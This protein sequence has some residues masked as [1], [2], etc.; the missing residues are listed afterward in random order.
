M[1]K[2]NTVNM[3]RV[4]VEDCIEV[5]PNRFELV[6]LAAERAKSI[7]SGAPLTIDR[8]NDKNPVIALREIA[9][10]TIDPDVLRETQIASLQ[11]HNKVDEVLEENLYAEVQESTSEEGDYS[12]A[13]YADEDIFSQ[14]TEVSTEEK[15]EFS[16]SYSKE[17]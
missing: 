9:T 15:T 5:V 14:E 13:S 3:A 7:S 16:V 11:K 10:K 12:Y 8:D 17:D 1:N 2:L 4:T 6:I